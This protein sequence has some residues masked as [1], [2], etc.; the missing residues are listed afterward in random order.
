MVDGDNAKSVTCTVWLSIFVY[1]KINDIV[2][3]RVCYHC[4]FLIRGKTFFFF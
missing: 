4:K 1:V 2:S 3:Q